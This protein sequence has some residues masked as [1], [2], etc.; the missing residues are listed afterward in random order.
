MTVA[1]QIRA[2]PNDDADLFGILAFFRHVLF[3][4][5]V[6][7][8]RAQFPRGRR[9]HFRRIDAV[10]IASGR[11]HFQI[12]RRGRAARTCRH[13]HAGQRGDKVRQF[14]ADALN[15]RQ[16]RFGDQRQHRV[17]RGRLRRIR[18]EILPGIRLPVTRGK[19]LQK[20]FRFAVNVAFLREFFR[21]RECFL[22]DVRVGNIKRFRERVDK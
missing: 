12:A 18:D 5:R 7:Q 16:N 11:Q 8:C 2:G 10:E 9:R 3:Q 19:R 20:F 21:C 14:R 1:A 6:A 15:F 17:Q 4:E 22:R 13:H